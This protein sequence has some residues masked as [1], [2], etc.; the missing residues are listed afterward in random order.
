VVLDAGR[1]QILGIAQDMRDLVD[2][3]KEHPHRRE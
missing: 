1:W 2:V 3:G